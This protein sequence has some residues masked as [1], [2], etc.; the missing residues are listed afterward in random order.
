MSLNY[1]FFQLSL[2]RQVSKIK[3]II[4]II[5]CNK[6]SI[7]VTL[8]LIRYFTSLIKKIYNSEIKNFKMTS[9]KKV[10]DDVKDNSN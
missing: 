7:I 10:T 5:K 9:N 6:V 2:I 4:T 8:S 3:L 1:F